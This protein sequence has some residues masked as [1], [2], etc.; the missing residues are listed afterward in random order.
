MEDIR[1]DLALELYE[2]AFTLLRQGDL[3]LAEGLLLRSI[4]VHPIADAHAWLGWSYQRRGR[5]DEA[6]AECKKAIAL[7]PALGNPYNDIG[8]SLI[9]LGREEEAVE[10]LEKA[11]RATRYATHH[12]AWHNLGRIWAARGLYNKARECFEMALEM[13]PAYEPAQTSLAALR[14]QVQ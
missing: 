10:W 5:L 1:K 12:F 2:K 3:E 6:I 11:T 7:D 8:E 14:R 13:E 4:E 9:E